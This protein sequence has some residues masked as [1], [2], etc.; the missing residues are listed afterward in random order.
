MGGCKAGRFWA[1]AGP[2]G[3]SH[4]TTAAGGSRAERAHFSPTGTVHGQAQEKTGEFQLSNATLL[5]WPGAGWRSIGSVSKCTGLVSLDLSNNSLAGSLT[6]FSAMVHLKTL[7]LA[8]NQ[9]VTLK[10]A[11]ALG[12]LQVLIGLGLGLGRAV[13]QPTS[14]GHSDSVCLSA[15]TMHPHAGP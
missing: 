12:M 1:A 8:G 9:L 13:Q 5:D 4:T 6:P 11:E 10:G 2:W 14:G 7:R 15:R 3:R